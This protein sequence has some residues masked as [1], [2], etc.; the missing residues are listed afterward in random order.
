MAEHGLLACA[1]MGSCTS[2]SIKEACLFHLREFGGNLDQVVGISVDTCATSRRFARMCD[3]ESNEVVTA[4][5][6]EE[7]GYAEMDIEDDVDSDADSDTIV[8][9]TMNFSKCYDSE[10]YSVWQLLQ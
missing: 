3:T 10:G 7:L 6:F 9:Q 8:K 5:D 4:K 2:L 1:T